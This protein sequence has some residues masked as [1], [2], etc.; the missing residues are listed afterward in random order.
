MFATCS[1]YTADIVQEPIQPTIRGRGSAH[2]PPNRFERMHV[3]DDFEHF[4]G[5]AEFLA[6]LGNVKTEYLIDTSRSIM[7]TN[8]SPDV[9]FTHSINPYRGCSHGC[10]YCYARPGHEYLG[11]SAGLDFETR[12][13][14]K[15]NAPQLLR[16]AL[17]SPKWE[18]TTVAMSG[19]TDSYQPIER[20]LELSRGCLKVL[21]EFRNP[22]GIVTKN[23]LVTRDIDLLKELAAVNAASVFISITTLDPKL[24]RIMEPRTSVPARR[25][26]AIE[27]LANAGVPVGVLMA[28]IVPG[29][30]D[31]EIPAVLKSAAD[32]GALTAGYVPLRLPLA[33]AGL[34][35]DWLGRYFPDRKEKVLNRVRSLRGGKLNDPNFNTRMRGQGIWAD[36]LTMMFETAKRKAGFD[37]RKM[38]KVSTAAFVNASEKQMSLWSV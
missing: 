12:I 18:P 19:V 35:E 21:A 8:D 13:M 29:L 6:E 26:A 2:N 7:A 32:A 17:S 5:D 10:I 22:V 30:T 25:L 16:E 1:V 11:M 36:Q 4:E 24:T 20:K 31:H 38:P 37:D 27:A 33:V 15:P 34:F 28:P 23:H 9:G 14:V 3:E